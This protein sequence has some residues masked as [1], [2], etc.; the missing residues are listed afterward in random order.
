MRSVKVVMVK[1]NW[2]EEDSIICRVGPNESDICAI[3]RAKRIFG[4][5]WEYYIKDISLFYPKV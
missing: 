1:G 2:P 5:S 4:E 3:N